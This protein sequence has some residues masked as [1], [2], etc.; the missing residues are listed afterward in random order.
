MNSRPLS[1]D[2]D[3]TKIEAELEVLNEKPETNVD[4]VFLWTD[5]W[6]LVKEIQLLILDQFVPMQF[7]TDF[8]IWGQSN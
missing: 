1:C 6:T 2:L 4:D 8:N 7:Y 3:L 5:L